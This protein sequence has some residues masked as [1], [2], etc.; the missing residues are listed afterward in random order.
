MNRA[1]RVAAKLNQDQRTAFDVIVES[2]YNSIGKLIFYDAYGQ[3]GK[4]FLWKSITTKLRSKGK[5]VL[6]VASVV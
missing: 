5:I 3:T 6:V 2:V 4:S 1:H